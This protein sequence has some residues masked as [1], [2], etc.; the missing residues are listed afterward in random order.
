MIIQKLEEL[1]AAYKSAG[2]TNGE[3][4]MPPADAIA[5]HR[6]SK[7]IDENVPTEL[8]D[9]WKVYG[10][11]GAIDNGTTGLFGRY[12]LLTPEFAIQ[13]YQMV[14]DDWFDII[15][16]PRPPSPGKRGDWVPGLIPFAGWDHFLLFIDPDTGFIWEF[17]PYSAIHG[18]FESFEN[19]L[20]QLLSYAPFEGDW[21]SDF[22]S[23]A[24]IPHSET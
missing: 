17:D 12:H 11:Q 21:E 15:E 20:D 19:M 13:D 2:V 24:F 5:V 22:S 16:D 18:F 14:R 1:I 10:G 3:E 6:L 7:E 4:L 23:S 8:N 9:I